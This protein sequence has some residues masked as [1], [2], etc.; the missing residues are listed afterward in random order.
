MRCYGTCEQ[1]RDRE[2]KICERYVGNFNV[3]YFLRKWSLT[4]FLAVLR[5]AETSVAEHL[6]KHGFKKQYLASLQIFA[7]KY[8]RSSE[9][10]YIVAQANATV[11]QNFDAS[12][13]LLKS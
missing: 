2:N 7:G 13:W 6:H 3:A 1:F 5:I 11:L 10:S 4:H 9:N 12:L 8:C